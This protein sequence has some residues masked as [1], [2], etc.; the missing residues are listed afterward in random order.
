[1]PIQ[2][3]G[4]LVLARYDEGREVYETFDEGRSV[5]QK[6]GVPIIVHF[7]LDPT[8]ALSTA[9]RVETIAV[10]VETSGTLTSARLVQ[11][12]PGQPV[13][14]IED[15]PEQFRTPPGA[16][17]QFLEPNP[18]SDSHFNLT[19]GNS[20]GTVT[21]SLDFYYGSAPAITTWAWGDYRQG[22]LGQTIDSVE[23][24]WAVT[25]VPAPTLDILPDV[26]FHPTALTGRFRHARTVSGSE[27]LS[28]QA[29]NRFGAVAA[30]LT[31]PWRSEG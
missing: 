2:D 3:E 27:T 7:S 12:T 17:V 5:F 19:L 23:I 29:T 16:S 21:R 1:M 26:N 10:Q 8:Q 30:N 9:A 25:G 31:I 4:R 11:Y 13:N 14:V 28:L 6:G 20:N 18:L 22:I 15:D 24:R